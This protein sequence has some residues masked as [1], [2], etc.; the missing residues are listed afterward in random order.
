LKLCTKDS[1][2][3]N[4]REKNNECELIRKAISIFILNWNLFGEVKTYHNALQMTN[5]QDEKL[6]AHFIELERFNRSIDELERMEWIIV[7]IF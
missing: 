4:E 1:E 5:K 3:S 2:E 7:H 6:E